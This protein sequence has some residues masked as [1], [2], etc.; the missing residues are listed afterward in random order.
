M[1]TPLLAPYWAP[2][3]RECVVNAPTVSA[4]KT[5]STVPLVLTSNFDD[6]YTQQKFE[7]SGNNLHM[8]STLELLYRC[9]RSNTMLGEVASTHQRVHPYLISFRWFKCTQVKF[10]VGCTTSTRVQRNDYMSVRAQFYYLGQMGW[11]WN[12]NLGGSTMGAILGAECSSF[13]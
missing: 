2:S 1:S 5:W 6:T 10:K 12:E 4:C 3:S 7:A 9:C 8:A 11:H 13:R